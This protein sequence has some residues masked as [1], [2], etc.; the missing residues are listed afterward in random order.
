M[1]ESRKGYFITFEG[2]EGSGKTTQIKR[3][4][5]AVVASGKKCI[6]TREPGG[7]P[8][9]EAIRKLLLTGA[10]DKWHPVAETLLF[11]AARV[12]HAEQVILP[13]LARGEIVLCDRFLDST[14]VY[15]GI[16]KKL[17]L[18]YI[19]L[20]HRMTLGTLAPDLTLLLD[21]DPVI[22]LKRAKGRQGHE[23]R[24]ENMDIAFHKNVREGFLA[25]AKAEPE[26]Y[27]IIDATQDA[28]KVARHVHDAFH[29][30]VL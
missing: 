25:L 19:R 26:R 22:G 1:S 14:I 5:D 27:A 18:E 2:G 10:G 6:I 15:Q 24:F 4:Y 3:L 29:K 13:A 30:I 17:G 16:G 28:E 11:Q 7:S 23:T 20:L 12:E 8:A 9:A 21:I